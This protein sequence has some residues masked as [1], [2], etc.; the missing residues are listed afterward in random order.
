[1]RMYYFWP[2]VQELQ[3][4]MLAWEVN[5]KTLPMGAMH[6]GPLV[7]SRDRLH[8]YLALGLLTIISSSSADLLQT[9]MRCVQPRGAR[10]AAR[11]ADFLGVVGYA[12]MGGMCETG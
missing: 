11:F 9:S 7:L 8:H 1:M 10:V 12:R 2:A 4:A 6:L 5:T 3:I